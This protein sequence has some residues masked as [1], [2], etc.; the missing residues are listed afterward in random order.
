MKTKTLILSLVTS[1]LVNIPSG[2]AKDFKSL[3]SPKTSKNMKLE[4]YP[5][6]FS[7]TKNKDCMEYNGTC[8]HQLSSKPI[9]IENFKFQTITEG[10]PGIELHIDKKTSKSF[11]KLAKKYKNGNLAVV[12][13]GKVVHVPTIKGIGGRDSFNMNFYNLNKFEIVLNELK[14]N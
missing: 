6:K 4:I 9:V 13:D 1:A 12:I 2:F 14:S 5:V 7:K 10:G 11:E 3:R 8:L